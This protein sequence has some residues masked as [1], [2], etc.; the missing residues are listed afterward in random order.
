M[1]IILLTHLQFLI[2]RYI[3][4]NT[5][6][7]NSKERGLKDLIPASPNSAVRPFELRAKS[8]LFGGWNEV[9]ES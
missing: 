7:F 9:V 2:A 1:D 5:H 8:Q 4:E 3:F 6:T